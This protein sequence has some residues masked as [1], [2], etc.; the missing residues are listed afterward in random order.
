MLLGRRQAVAEQVLETLFDPWL[1]RL[2]IHVDDVNPCVTAG[3]RTLS[4]Y[5]AS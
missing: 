4:R 5:R 1:Y 3:T 2:Q